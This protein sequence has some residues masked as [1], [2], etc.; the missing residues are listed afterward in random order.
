MKITFKI[1][2]VDLFCRGIDAPSPTT[3]LEVNPSSLTENQRQLFVGHLL[4]TDD[5][6]DVVHDSERARQLVETVPVGGHPGADLIEAKEPTLDSLLEALAELE[7]QTNF[8]PRTT[9]NTRTEFL[10][11]GSC[12]SRLQ[13]PP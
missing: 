2:Q 4:P 10:S 13:F 7:L 5:G 3:S 6:C 11:R 1:D 8:S 9:Q 12:G